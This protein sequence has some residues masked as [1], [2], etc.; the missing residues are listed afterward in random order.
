M[1]LKRVAVL[2]S[3]IAGAA[4]TAEAQND[5]RY[6]LDLNKLLNDTLS[7]ELVV[8]K[9]QQSTLTFCFPKII[10]GTY[11]ISDYGKFISNVKALDKFGK[12]LPVKKLSD[13]K[14]KITNAIGLTTL[15]YKVAD[16]FDSEIKHG[17]YP[18]AATNF[19]EGR[20]FVIHTPGF[21]GFFEG[22]NQL[23][24]TVNITKP[25][26]LYGSTSLTP[27][28]QT[29]SKDV[30]TVANVDELYD[31]PI[32][33]TMPDTTTITVGNCRV[34]VSVYSREKIYSLNK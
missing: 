11:A 6:S 4:T 12:L 17:I 24:F 27:I 32:M 21:F 18:M 2:F 20:N 5:Y 25:A 15:S 19:E 29:A 33:Y 14:W 1:N 10:P 13:N 16:I 7:I 9:L 26:N 31:S 30:F 34:L 22:Y 23:P 28:D 8:P 3:L